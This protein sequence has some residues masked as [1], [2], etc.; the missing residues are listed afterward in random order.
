MLLKSSE[1]LV[2]PFNCSEFLNG[3]FAFRRGLEKHLHVEPGLIALFGECHCHVKFRTG[4]VIVNQA[5]GFYDLNIDN[6]IFVVST[7]RTVHDESP[8][9]ARSHINFMHRVREPVWPPPL[10]QVFW[11]GPNLPDEFTRRIEETRGDDFWVSCISRAR[12]RHWDFGE[13]KLQLQQW[14]SFSLPRS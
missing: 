9:A 2:Q 7:I 13:F 10:S 4:D 1:R 11:I 14:N 3:I 5:L 8:D 12:F 6:F